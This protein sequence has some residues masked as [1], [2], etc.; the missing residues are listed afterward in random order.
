MRRRPPDAGVTTRS[1]NRS[2]RVPPPA[3]TE[4]ADPVVYPDE[5]PPARKD[6]RSPA[7]QRQDAGLCPVLNAFRETKD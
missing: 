4:W 5:I 7:R 3:S 1:A 6:D 2:P